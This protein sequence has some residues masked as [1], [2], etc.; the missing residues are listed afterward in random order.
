MYPNPL[1]I[2]VRPESPKYGLR[3]LWIVRVGHVNDHVVSG[4]LV[5]ELL[6]LLY[7]PMHNADIETMK[8]VIMSG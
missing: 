5:D 4:D 2:T 3:D 7:H 8:F 6:R 1:S